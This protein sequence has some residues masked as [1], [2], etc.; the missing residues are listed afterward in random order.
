M[1]EKLHQHI[2][3]QEKDF[4]EFRKKLDY[5]TNLTEGLVQRLSGVESDVKSL[6]KLLRGDERTADTGFIKKVNEM[7]EFIIEKNT[8]VK[9]LKISAGVFGFVLAAMAAAKGIFH[10]SLK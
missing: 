5:N 7:H 10:I 6:D 8:T 9:I 2:K 3:D 4:D 1:E